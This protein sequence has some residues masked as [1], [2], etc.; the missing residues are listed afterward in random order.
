MDKTESIAEVL[1]KSQ[2]LFHGIR[3][4]VRGMEIVSKN[5]HPFQKQF[6]AHP[7]AVVVLPFLD[8]D[9]ILMIR[10]YRFAVNETLWELPAGTLEPGEPPLKTAYRELIEETGYEA[11]R[12]EPLHAFYTTPGI[13]NEIMYAYAAY[14]LTYVGQA[15]EETE[16]I[17]V[18]IVEWEKVLNWVKTGI[19]CDAKTIATLFYASIQLK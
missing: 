19:I 2:C 14:D 12:I 10:N 9:R 8:K 16:D 15:L 11:K 6:V 1:G 18:A 3:F 7:G 5:G 17:E 4:D 13:C